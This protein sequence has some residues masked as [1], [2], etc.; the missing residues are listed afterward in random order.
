MNVLRP[1]AARGAS[2]H[3]PRASFARVMPSCIRQPTCTAAARSGAAVAMRPYHVTT[4][5]KLRAK[6]TFAK[7]DLSG[8]T[9]V[10][11]GGAQGLGLAMAEGLA[12]AGAS[13]YCLDYQANPSKE[14]LEA[15]TDLQTDNG[16][17]LHFQQVDVRNHAQLEDVIL[18]LAAKRERLDGVIAAAGVQQLC[19]ALEY[20]YEDAKRM[21]DINCTGVFFTAQ[22]AAKAMTRYRSRGKI[23]LIAS[24]SGLIANKGLISPMYNC[25]KAAVIQ[26]ARSLSMEWA[27]ANSDGTGGIRVN[28]L[29]PGNIMTPMVKKNFE[30]VPGLKEKWEAE[31]MMGRLAEPTE[32]KGAAL[33]LLSDHSSFMTGSSL[34]IDA[35]YTAW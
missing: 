6:A 29:C 2:S 1:V 3:V 25:S 7:F 27:R 15:Q 21:L 31:N 30:E 17:Q 19:P 13:V 4:P 16:G 8:Q 12:E 18:N 23:C 28:A 33:F 24:M 32:F 5:P 35:G 9:H 20:T 11:T 22:A 14:F 34:V 26:M 10:V